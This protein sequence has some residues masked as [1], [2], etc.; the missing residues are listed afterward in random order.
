MKLKQIKVYRFKR[1]CI[2][3]GVIESENL[4]ESIVTLTESFLT[5]ALES[6]KNEKIEDGQLLDE[7]IKVMLPSQEEKAKKEWFEGLEFGGKKYYGWFA[8]TGG[9]KKEN[10]GKCETIFVRE[11]F[12]EFAKEFEDLI[13]LSK[14]KEIDNSKEEICINKDILSRISLGTSS[15]YMA[16]DM[17]NIIVLPQPTFHIIKDYKTVKKFNKKVENKDGK[18]KEQVDYNLVDHH[19]DDKIDVF[20][21]GGIATPQVFKQIQKELQIKYP[22]EFAIIRAYGIGIKGMITKFD[23]IKYL[24]VF[25]KGDTEYCKKENETFYLLDMWNE[26]QPVTDNTMLLNESMVKLAKYYKVENN[27]N[28]ET[29]KQRLSSVDDKYREIINKLYVTKINKA[30]EDISDYRRTNYQLLNALAL[31]KKDYM[32]LA[33]EDIKAYRRILKPFVKNEKEQWIANLDNIRLFF[34]NIVTVSD[35]ED[36]DDETIIDLS[37]KNIVNKCEELLHISEDFIHL[38]FVKNNLARLIEKKCRELAC[39]KLTTKA[40]YQYIAVDPIS[41]MNYAMTREQGENGLNSGEFYSRDCYDSDIRTIARNPLCAYSEVHNVKFVRNPFLDNY[42]SPCRELIYFNQKSDILALMS[43]ADTDGDACTV[44]DSDII[45]NAVVVPKDGKYFINTD[46]GQKELMEYNLE[47][48]FL[49]TYRASGNLIGSIALKSVNINSNSQQTY[50][51]YDTV[52]NKFKLFKRFDG[53]QK[54]AKELYKKE[55]NEKLESGEWISTYNASEQHREHIRQRF[56]ENEKEIYIVLYN[57]MVSIDAPKTLYFP[58]KKDMEIIDKKY[59]RKAWFLQYKEKAENVSIN[60]YQYTFGLLDGFTHV[61]KEELL[62]E[63]NKITEGFDDKVEIIQKKLINGDYNVS[64]YNECL[65]E[66]TKLYTDYSNER[67]EI[68][69]EYN[70]KKYKEDN[71]RNLMIDNCSWGDWEEEAYHASISKFKK[72]KYKQYKEVDAKYIVLADEI[73]K[74][75]DIATIANTIANLKNCTE[76]FII[77]LFYP[78]FPHINSKLQGIRYIYIKSEDGD[79]IYLHETYKKSPYTIS[80]NTDI[81][82][83]LHLEEKKRL[84]VINVKQDVRAKIL[85]KDVIPLIQ[86]EL[87]NNGQIVFDI[88]VDDNKVILAKEKKDMLE[89]FNE[90]IQIKE[91]NLLVC[92]SVKFELL[93]DI[94]KTKKSLKLTVT[95]ITL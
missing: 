82:K 93:V 61:V 35:D 23:I 52:N 80:D 8:T 86:S 89:V 69:K 74:K 92:S 46:D 48:R 22:V 87:K 91:Y 15:C 24:D 2:D 56:Y 11:D 70:R 14:F 90:F 9:M 85:D 7:I 51:Y 21:G 39:G 31:N 5:L 71:H 44:I 32:E 55:K 57:A 50:D 58:T 40:K 68:N 95:E 79:I 29:Y 41:Y 63:I 64:Q 26:W 84:N 77:N 53:N 72:K 37:N 28:M 67:K 30:D 42:L 60:H 49:A 1:G 47:N 45:R 19:F 17:P 4:E 66:I 12:L 27:E 36:V 65:D 18:I 20:D 76:A 25:Y 75:Y 83:N 81:V 33:K 43:S 34:K 73:F 88:R 3:K 59:P 78:V 54:E 13:S 10:S 62:N 94:A 38:K 6:Y 16:G